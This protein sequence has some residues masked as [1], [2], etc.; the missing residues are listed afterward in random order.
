MKRKRVEQVATLNTD[1]VSHIPII[2]AL[3]RILAHHISYTDFGGGE[4]TKAH[5][6]IGFG[7]F[8]KIEYAI[9]SKLTH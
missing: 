6:G 5:L 1:Q 4:I 8:D 2:I 9:L 3:S 7:R